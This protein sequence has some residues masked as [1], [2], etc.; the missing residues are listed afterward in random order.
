M[1]HDEVEYPLASEFRPERFLSKV[2]YAPPRDPRSLI[3]GFGRR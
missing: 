3:Y 2:G 1:L